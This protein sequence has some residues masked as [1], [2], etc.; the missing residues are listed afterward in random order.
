MDKSTAFELE[1]N[2]I[3]EII[4]EKVIFLSREIIRSR[5][6]REIR[7]KTIN[8]KRLSKQSLHELGKEFPEDTRPLR[9]KNR[10]ECVN[11]PRPCPFVSCSHHLYLDV[12]EKTGSIKLNFPDIE[13]WEMK[14]SCALD[15]AD[16]G[17]TTLEDT[18]AIMNITRERVRQ[19]EVQAV[20]KLESSRNAKVLKEFL[21]EDSSRTATKRRLPI[22]QIGVIEDDEDEDDGGMSGAPSQLALS[23]WLE[24]VTRM[25]VSP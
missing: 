4:E 3:D 15:V 5:R 25:A 16:R 10:A 22:V 24:K 1:V 17:E 21:G 7:A 23:D 19:L 9:P 13:V 14:D 6:K 11:A 8:T 18:G 20:A 2:E 12:S